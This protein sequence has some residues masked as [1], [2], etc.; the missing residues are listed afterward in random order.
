MSFQDGVM[1]SDVTWP[2]VFGAATNEI[3][4]LVLFLKKNVTSMEN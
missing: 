2:P 3:S 4:T 1:S